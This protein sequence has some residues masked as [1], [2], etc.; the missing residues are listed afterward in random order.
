VSRPSEAD[1]VAVIEAR[2]LA[3]GWRVALEEQLR[4]LSGGSH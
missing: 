4:R 2:G 3:Y 1:L